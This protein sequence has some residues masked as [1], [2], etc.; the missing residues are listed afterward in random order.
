M[1][2]A[3]IVK[4]QHFARGYGLWLSFSVCCCCCCS[5]SVKMAA[6]TLRLLPSDIPAVRAVIT[7]GRSPSQRIP[8][9][10]PLAFPTGHYLGRL[11]LGF[12]RLVGSA[13]ARH[14]ASARACG[15]PISMCGAVSQFREDFSHP[16]APPRLQ[17]KSAPVFYS[18]GCLVNANMVC[19]WIR[20]S[21]YCSRFH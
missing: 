21:A 8:R 7:H 5:L 12:A 18:K 9:A 16:S 15:S 14:R 1:F 3:L 20:K 13:F 10:S 6:P 2:L 11:S 4:F 17:R 19:P